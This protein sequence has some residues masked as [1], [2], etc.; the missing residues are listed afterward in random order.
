MNR[1]RITRLTVLAVVAG[2]IA[3]P[4]ASAGLPPEQADMHASTT[5]AVADARTNQD[6]RN[7]DN[8]TESPVAGKQDLRTP[9]AVDAAAGRGT[10]SAPDVVVVKVDDPKP[11]PVADGLDWGDAGIGAG[12]IAGL[13]LITLGGGLVLTQRRHA[14]AAF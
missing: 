6:F 11:Q 10:F 3:A 4:T 1:Q 7:P 9:D 14:R 5:Q 12:V 13:S 2:A 8:R